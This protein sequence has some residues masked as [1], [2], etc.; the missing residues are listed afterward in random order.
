M[1]I[2]QAVPELGSVLVHNKPVNTAAAAS[3]DV[4]PVS[5]QFHCLLLFGDIQ[6]KKN[7]MGTEASNGNEVAEMVK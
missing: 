4:T 1:P 6:G 3:P 7:L 2:W 5:V